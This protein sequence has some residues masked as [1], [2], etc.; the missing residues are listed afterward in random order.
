MRG[1]SKRLATAAIVLLILAIGGFAAWPTLHKP[2]SAYASFVDKDGLDKS[3][4]QQFADF[5][6]KHTNEIVYLRTWAGSETLQEGLDKSGPAYTLPVHDP[7]CHDDEGCGGVSYNF[8][9]THA[10]SIYW[11]RAYVID[12]FFLVTPIQ[13]S[14]QGWIEIALEEVDRAEVILKMGPPPKSE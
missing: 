6:D 13:G 10:D 1:K 5:I 11:N 12:G 8:V 3:G 7:T 4:R 14:H 2:V 9:V